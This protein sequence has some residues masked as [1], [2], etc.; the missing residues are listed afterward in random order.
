MSAT[1]HDGAAIQAWGAAYDAVPKSVFALAAWHLANLASGALD[2][3][4]AAEARFAWEVMIL[5]QGG[6]ISPTQAGRALRSLPEPVE[7][8]H[9]R[10][11]GT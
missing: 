8:W 11:A 10:G 4:G 2:H 1:K 6:H 9:D 5:G 3:P 7:D